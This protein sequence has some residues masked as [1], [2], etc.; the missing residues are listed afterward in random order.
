MI[1]NKPA[2]KDKLVGKKQSASNKGQNGDRKRPRDQSLKRREP[3]QFTPLSISY[4]R[5]LPLIRNLPDFKWPTPIQAYP[6]QRNKSFLCDY[7]RDHRHETDR[8]RS[9]KFLVEKFI[10][11]GHL[12]RYLRDAEQG[13]ESGQPTSRITTSPTVQLEPRLTINYILGDPKDDRY[14]SKCQRKK[15]VRAS[16]VNARVNVVHTESGQEAEPI[17]DPISFAQI[18]LNK[19]II[20]HCDAL[21]LTHCINGFDMHRVLVNPGSAADL[22]QLPA[23]TQMKLFPSMLNSARQIL[24]GFNGATTITLGDV[25]LP[26]ES[27]VSHS[28]GSILNR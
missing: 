12:R 11:A 4:E 2:E 16:T 8:Y 25:T 10:K 17:D 26:C 5:L 9:L 19:V 20:P 24:S 13:V 22:L 7:Y 15:L 21:V 27:R 1:T 6:A 23:I 3:P 18:N 28:T 14:Q